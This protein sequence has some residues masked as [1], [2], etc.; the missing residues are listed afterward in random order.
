M[1]KKTIGDHSLFVRAFNHGVFEIS[2][3]LSKYDVSTR[4]GQA[5]CSLMGSVMVSN[6]GLEGR[7]K[8]KRTTDGDCTIVGC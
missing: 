2:S 8:W 3:F 1:K 4:P 5:C 6:L 7:M